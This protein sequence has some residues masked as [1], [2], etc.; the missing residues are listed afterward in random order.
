MA[1]LGPL[2][3]DK[4]RVEEYVQAARE[5]KSRRSFDGRHIEDSVLE[6]MREALDGLCT[7][8]G[9]RVH[10]IDIAPDNLFKGIIGSY[11]RIS[12]AP[13]ALAFIGQATDENAT[14]E[15]GYLGQAAVLEATRL[16]LATCWVGGY[17]NPGRL[18]KLVD[19]RAGELAHAVSPLGYGKSSISGSERTLYRMKQDKT[20]PRKPLDEIAPGFETWPE[21]ARDGVAIAR[22]APSAYNRQPWRF[23]KDDA[24]IVVS[25]EGPDTPKISKRIGCGIAMLSFEMGAR[26]AGASGHWEFVSH[27]NDVAAFVVE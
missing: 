7:G 21:W 12:G 27:A 3:I 19:M 11:G 26:H 9:A 4:T 22:L 18:A 24:R 2:G 8:Q 10:L 17:F 6:D 1:T 16:G 5:R 14:A 23:R 20:K 15:I 25:F 13:S